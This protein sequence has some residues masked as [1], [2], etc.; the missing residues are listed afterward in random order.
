MVTQLNQAH[1]GTKEIKHPEWEAAS[2]ALLNLEFTSKLGLNVRSA[3]KNATQYLLNYVHFGGRIM[4][5]SKEF[6]RDKSMEQAVE[7]SL[8]ESGL[9]FTK[10]AVELLETE[11][12]KNMF[13]TKVKLNDIGEIEFHNPGP[14]SQFAN[15]T[16]K[17]AGAAGQ[18]KVLLPGGKDL[19]VTPWKMNM[20]EIENINRTSTYKIAFSKMYREL[21]NNDAFRTMNSEKTET[22]YLN[23][24]K[25][26]SQNYAERMTTL[27]HF[28]YSTASKSKIMRGGIGRFLF[29]FQHYG[30][31]FAELNA[32]IGREA[33]Q[34]AKA[35]DF[36]GTEMGRAYRMAMAYGMVP[37]I[38]TAIT[39]LD[40]GRLVQHDT[41]ERIQGLWTMLT[42]DEEE[43]KK[44]TYGRGALGAFIGAPVISD[45]LA[46][47]EMMELWDL[48]D[49]DRL[50]MAIGYT[51]YANTSDDEKIAKLARI[52]N[53]QLS[54]TFYDTGQLLF[55]GSIGRF[56]Q[57]EMGLYPTSDARKKQEM[58][59]NTGEKWLPNAVWDALDRIQEHTQ[60][61]RKGGNRS[62]DHRRKHI[63]SFS[64]Y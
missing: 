22:Q 2:R 53:I 55:S 39:G 15:F 29:Q 11:G 26:R 35:K 48:S 6:Y 8:E 10:K 36:F 12:T 56:A 58:L 46:I 41:L 40:M 51:D 47:G 61:A 17:V 28:D 16:S 14:M 13:G 38:I 7:K 52:A 64:P 42:G 31:K 60:N 34:A 24:I 54:R 63:S 23:E 62:R 45:A 19:K 50:Q 25:R 27:L 21:R 18:G 37:G 3:A 9:K 30:Y 49:H 33:I 44:A 32:M 4:R 59:L 1:L 20:L 5:D 43:I 57:H